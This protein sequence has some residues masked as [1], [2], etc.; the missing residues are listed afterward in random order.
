MG[1]GG[2]GRPRAVVSICK[3]QRSFLGNRNFFLVALKDGAC[4]PREADVSEILGRSLQ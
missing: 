4:S 1:S 2:V 3:P